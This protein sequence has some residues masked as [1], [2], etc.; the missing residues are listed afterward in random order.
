MKRKILRCAIGAAIVGV[1]LAPAILWSGRSAI[2][3]AA[4]DTAVKLLEIST[5]GPETTPYV[6]TPAEREKLKLPAFSS[7]TPLDLLY[8]ARPKAVVGNE[9]P[10]PG[11]T[12][13][14]LEK[15]AAWRARVQAGTV[16]SAPKTIDF[17]RKPISMFDIVPRAP[18]IEGMTPAEKVKAKTYSQEGGAK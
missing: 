14:E 4:R 15:L 3:T 13:A 9:R 5:V 8:D 17:P 6:L 11:M 16:D 1:V 12:P 18:G 10:Y 2:D 7:P